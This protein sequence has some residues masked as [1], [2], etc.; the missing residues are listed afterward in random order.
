MRTYYSLIILLLAVLFVSCGG[1]EPSCG[2]ED[3]DRVLYAPEYAAG[4]SI[5]GAEDRKSV[6]VT[7]QNPWQGA[8]SV[9]TRLFIA[10][11]DEDVPDGFSGQV[12]RGDAGRIIA[13][14]STHV[15]MLDA[16]DAGDRVAGVSGL[17]YIFNFNIHARSDR[18]GDVG[19]D[20]NVNYELILA[21]EPDIVLL[22]GVNCASPMES[23][24]RELGIPYI[25]IGDYLEESPLGKAEWL[26]LISEIVGMREKGEQVF[27]DIAAR[28]EALRNKVAETVLDAP[29]VM[30]NTPYGDAWFMP[31]TQ[32]YVARLVTDA[33]GDCIYKKN[34]GNVSV[35]IDMEEAYV[36]TSK[37]DMWI[38]VGNAGSLAELGAACP[39]F[40]DTRC[41]LNGFVYNNNR[42][43]NASGGNDYYESAVVNPDVLLRDL[44]K[45]LHPELVDEDFVYYKQLK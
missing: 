35:P 8:D 3:F 36:L 37:A 29:S 20:G 1:R 2:C 13:M 18:V 21:L 7:V 31:S 33:G 12:L 23:K 41:F 27:G 38:N 24:L 39:K 32:S 11:G 45:I 19:Y 44:V 34:T 16:V 26:V 9:T 43:V 5:K 4:F 25:Y 28:Y 42:R 14:S 17:G 10:R 40:T 30:F 22:Y 6:L 15:A